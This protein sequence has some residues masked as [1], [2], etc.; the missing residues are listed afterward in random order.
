MKN[1]IA[2]FLLLICLPSNSQDKYDYVLC[3]GVKIFKDN[4]NKFVTACSLKEESLKE[5]FGNPDTIMQFSQPYSYKWTI[6]GGN[7]FQ[8]NADSKNAIDIQISKSSLKIV[9][10]DTIELKIGSSIEKIFL[11]FP[12]STAN[13][14]DSKNGFKKFTLYY[15]HDKKTL[16]DIKSCNSWM[17][18]DYNPLTKSIYKI[19]QYNRD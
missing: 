15:I 4:S 11:Y 1:M 5:A 18:I 9:I 19:H 7:I 16:L 14:D 13:I 3:E 8:F 17:I 2:L 12:R 10:L 6:Y